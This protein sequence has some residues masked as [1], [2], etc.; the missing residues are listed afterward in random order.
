MYDYQGNRIQTT[1]NGTDITKYLVDTNGELSQVIAE[2][3][4]NNN[5]LSYYTLGQELISIEKDSK[6]YYYCYDGHGNVRLLTDKNGVVTDTYV[7]D[8]FGNVTKKTGSTDNNYLY[9][10]QQYST[11][12]G[13]Y[14][15]RARYMN[16]E[17]GTFISSDT[18]EGDESSPVTLHKY[19]YANANPVTYN[20]LSGYIAE[21]VLESSY[22]IRVAIVGISYICMARALVGVINSRSGVM[23]NVITGIVDGIDSMIN[24]IIT[25]IQITKGVYD[26][27]QKTEM[28]NDV[29]K[30]KTPKNFGQG[31]HLVYVLIDKHQSIK[32]YDVKYTFT[33]KYVGRT[34]HEDK[35]KAAH[36]RNPQKKRYTFVPVYMGLSKNNAR[37]FEQALISTFV[38]GKYGGDLVNKIRGIAID[39]LVDFDLTSICSHYNRLENEML[40]LMRQ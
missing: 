27:V 3:D 9:C 18:Y 34:A 10:A 19:L 1:A 26:L 5:E 31:E 11:N 22:N 33:V 39:R 17:T 28:E 4:K 16:T 20:D 29:Q 14:Y 30:R 21:L 40:D 6:I 32:K 24:N 35:R 36:K 25:Q 38:L 2:F 13:L 8:A 12:T 15:L 23:I 7:Y 37:V